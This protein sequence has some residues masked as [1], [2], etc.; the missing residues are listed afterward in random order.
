MICERANDA[1]CGVNEGAHTTDCYGLSCALAES[2]N[3][4]HTLGTAA[5]CGMRT[6]GRLGLRVLCAIL[7]V[8]LSGCGGDAPVT[9]GDEHVKHHVLG[10]THQA[11]T[12]QKRAIHI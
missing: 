4:N 6:A 7:S 5:D 9:W 8:I 3:S 1:D 10:I 12:N 11:A 2:I